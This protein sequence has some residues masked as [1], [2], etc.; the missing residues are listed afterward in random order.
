M[1]NA[2]TKNRISSSG[3]LKDIA[4]YQPQFYHIIHVP[5]RLEEMSIGQ[6]KSVLS[7]I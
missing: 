2:R 1:R 5:S 7:L 4:G 3:L 6:S